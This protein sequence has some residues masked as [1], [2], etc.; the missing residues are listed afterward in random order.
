MSVRGLERVRVRAGWMAHEH[1]GGGGEQEASPTS[2][3]SSCVFCYSAAI[4]P[5]RRGGA[6]GPAIRRAC[7]KAL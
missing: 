1:G 3:M 5:I 4:L 2:P 6:D 7:Y